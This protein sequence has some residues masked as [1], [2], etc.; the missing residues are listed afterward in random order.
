[1]SKK[2]DLTGKRFGRLVVLEQAPSQGKGT[3]R[4]TMWRCQCDCGQQTV[5]RSSHLRNG[6]IMSCGCLLNE[7]RKET[8][9][10]HGESHQ[11]LYIVWADMKQRCTNPKRPR[12]PLYGGR[13]IRV[14][15]EWMKSYQS[16]RDWAFASGYDESAPRGECTL[17][18]IDN[19]G[20]Y[21]PDNCRW[22][23][24]KEQCK[25]RHPKGYAKEG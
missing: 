3:A 19:D 24:M 7:R 17:D 9:T 16:F 15:D 5:V 10:S 21:C 6:L 14:C 1:M 23:N 18:R 8:R 2:I 4:R 20:D 11:R 13:G 25:N 22:V 12:Y